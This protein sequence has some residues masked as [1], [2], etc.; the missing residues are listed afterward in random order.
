MGYVIVEKTTTQQTSKN[1]LKDPD[2]QSPDDKLQ[3]SVSQET[4]R[5]SL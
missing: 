5:A 1:P 3:E 4:F 2:C